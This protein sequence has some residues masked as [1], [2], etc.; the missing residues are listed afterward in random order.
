MQNIHRFHNKN[1]YV[2]LQSYYGINAKSSLFICSNLGFNPKSKV[3]KLNE[4]ELT[5]IQYFLEQNFM[6]NNDLK[7][8]VKNNILTLIKVKSYKGKRHHL[9]LPVRGQRTKSNSKTR[10]KLNFYA[11]VIKNKPTVRATNKKKK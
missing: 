7:Q 8:E 9:G 4:I 1:I 2:F 11:K 5:K 10:K 3:S 6:L